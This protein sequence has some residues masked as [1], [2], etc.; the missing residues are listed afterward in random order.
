MA[1][2]ISTVLW[3]IFTI[4]ILQYSL[5]K[6]APTK[7][8]HDF[9][10]HLT[11]RIPSRSDCLSAI[12][13]DLKSDTVSTHIDLAHMILSIGIFNTT[14]SLNWIKSSKAKYNPG[15][16]IEC[17][18]GFNYAVSS[19]ASA[20]DVVDLN[21]HAANSEAT[22]VKNGERYCIDGFTSAK[23]VMPRQIGKRL[24]YIDLYSMLGVSIIDRLIH[25]SRH[26]L[27]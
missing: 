11:K 7:L 25:D 23:V 4:S 18:T 26:I 14:N 9:C 17:I 12:A 1:S 24:K 15:A 21:L 27:N 3:T 16:I 13:V 10:N 2:T 6:A 5:V 19:F 8:V 22:L 20:L